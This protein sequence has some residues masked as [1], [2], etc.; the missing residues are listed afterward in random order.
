[1]PEIDAA[2]LVEAQKIIDQMVRECMEDPDAIS[3]AL[4][5]IEAIP[6]ELEL[7][8]PRIVLFTAQ[9]CEHCSPEREKFQP[10]LEQGK[11]T[12]I[13]ADTPAGQAIMDRNNL[14]FVPSL[15]LLDCNDNLIA[16]F[17]DSREQEDSD[18]PA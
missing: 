5:N 16:E 10:L 18:T 12:E 4:E 11:I 8:K 7:C 3:C 17:F 9:D 1:M 6:D 13:D 15:V 14:E 2:Q